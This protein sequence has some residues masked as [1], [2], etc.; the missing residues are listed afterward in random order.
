MVPAGMR[1]RGR[2]TPEDFGP[3]PALVP[4]FASTGALA[5]QPSADGQAT[6]A[7]TQKSS[8]RDTFQT[9]PETFPELFTEGSITM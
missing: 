5:N 4:G 7:A 6:L 2:D 8:T 3:L 1:V 9:T